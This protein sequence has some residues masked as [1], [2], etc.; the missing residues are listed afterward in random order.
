[1]EA[2]RSIIVGCILLTL[3]NSNLIFCQDSLPVNVNDTV[4]KKVI[5][6]S[7]IPASKKAELTLKDTSKNQNKTEASNY[8]KIIRYNGDSILCKINNKNVYEIE[9]TPKGSKKK[10]KISTANVKG[11]YYSNGKFESLD[12]TPEKKKKEW[13]IN[14]ASDSSLAEFQITKN[15]IFDKIVKQNDD[16]IFCTITDK[17]LYEISFIKPN[18]KYENKISTKTIKEIF[19]SDGKYELVD[20]NPEKKNKEWVVTASEIEWKNIIITSKPEE[21]AGLIDKGPMEAKFEA[22]KTNTDNETLERSVYTMLKRKAYSMKATTV[23]VTKKNFFRAYGEIP[24]VEVKAIA[25][26]KE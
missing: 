24:Y 22:K 10:M 2:R 11:I 17:N 19:Y 12:T 15:I 18:S 16:T 5:A 6:D 14:S 26:G 8:D 7:V 3:L 1:M 25:Y 23:L 20:N 4:E 21:V 9:Y 13:V